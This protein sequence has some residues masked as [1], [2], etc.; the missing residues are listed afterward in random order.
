MGSSLDHVSPSSLRQLVPPASK[1]VDLLLDG[2]ISLDRANTDETRS[3]LPRF[4]ERELHSY[5]SCGLLCHGFARVHCPSCSHDLARR[6]LIVLSQAPAEGQWRAV[7][8]T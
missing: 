8:V 1:S 4:V 2:F 3:R 6:P 5:L 7:G